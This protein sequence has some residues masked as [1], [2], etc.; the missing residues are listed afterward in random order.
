VSAELRGGF[1][2]LGLQGSAPSKDPKRG[3]K[4]VALGIGAVITLAV[5]ALLLLV[6]LPIAADQVARAVLFVARL[7]TGK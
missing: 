7:V 5:A 2:E 6:V 4:L 1:A 3:R